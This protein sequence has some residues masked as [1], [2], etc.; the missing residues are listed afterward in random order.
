MFVADVEYEATVVEV[1]ATFIKCALGSRVSMGEGE[2]IA[3]GTLGRVAGVRFNRVEC[4]PFQVGDVVHVYPHQMLP[5]LPSKKP[6][7]LLS[8]AIDK[9]YIKPLLIFDIHGVLGILFS[10]IHNYVRC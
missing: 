4:R 6:G 2:A 7:Q 3:P 8:L 10:I 5:K 9:K 1:R